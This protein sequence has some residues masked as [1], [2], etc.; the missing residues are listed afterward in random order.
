MN[1]DE[2]AKKQAIAFIEWIDWNFD[3]TSDGDYYYYEKN[4]YFSI[5]ELYDFFISDEVIKKSWFFL[6]N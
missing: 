6:D 5:M 2:Y 3:R 1:C 4:K